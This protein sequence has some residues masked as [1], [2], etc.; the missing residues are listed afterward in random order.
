MSIQIIDHTFRPWLARKRQENG[1]ATYSKDIQEVLIPRLTEYFQEHNPELDIL[2]STAPPLAQVEDPY[3]LHDRPELVIQF[4]HTYPYRNPMEPINAMLNRF[5]DSK[6]ILVTAYVAYEIRINQWAKAQGLTDRVKP[7]FVPMFIQPENILEAVGKRWY[8]H[9]PFEKRII[10]FGNLYRAKSQEYYRIRQGLERAGWKVDVISKS[11]FNGTG[12]VLEQADTW[13]LISQY[14]YGIG[15][16]RCAL[17]M[18]T[19]GLKVLISGEHWGGLCMDTNDCYTQQKTNF[20]GRVITGS[21]DLEEALQ[22][23]PDSRD[24]VEFQQHPFAHAS[25]WVIMAADQLLKKEEK[26][27]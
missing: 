17:E 25:K 14:R 4:L 6:V 9:D 20:N 22:L 5:P 19:L 12:P 7:V 27:L 24:G 23:L 1:A 2:I 8:K 18:Y 13:K 10:Y 3:I 21:R 16:G 26:P 11:R 15:V